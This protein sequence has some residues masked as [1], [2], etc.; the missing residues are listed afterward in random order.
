MILFVFPVNSDPERSTRNT[1]I[2]IILTRIFVLCF[3]N[4]NVKFMFDHTDVRPLG[5]TEVISFNIFFLFLI[6]IT[7]LILDFVRFY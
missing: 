2:R 1:E 7:I 3:V 6:G 4:S 5:K